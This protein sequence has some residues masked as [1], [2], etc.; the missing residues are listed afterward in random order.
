M[1]Q[2]VAG[3]LSARASTLA[4]HLPDAVVHRMAAWAF[5]V[6]REQRMLFLDE[7]VDPARPAA[8]VGAWW[9]PWTYWLSRRC[10]EVWTFEPNP[11]LATV[12]RG[13]CRD[14]VRVCEVGLSDRAG[15][16]ALYVPRAV[17]PDAQ[18]TLVPAHRM[19]DADE[20]TV[21]LRRLDDFGLH[22]LGF[23]KIDVEAHE[24]EV[25]DGA[26]ETIA[27]CRPV[28]LI[29]IEQRFHDEPVSRLFERMLAHDYGGWFRREHTWRPL[30]DFDVERDQ[31]ATSDDPKSL[32]YVN[33]FVFTPDGRVPAESSWSN[34]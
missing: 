10:P 1:R 24:A 2:E 16:M 19:P 33:N 18:S 29:E 32:A 31:T 34:R 5:R 15:A 13:V 8:D 26:T 7:L 11:A 30:G 9:G 22:D 3:V 28:V 27:R 4:L 17:G 14:N 6:R 25:L 21:E 23:V 12:L 20:V